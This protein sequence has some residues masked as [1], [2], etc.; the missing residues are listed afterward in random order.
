MET[1]EVGRKYGVYDMVGVCF[2]FVIVLLGLSVVGH[3]NG[4]SFGCG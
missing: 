4:W 3:G 2:H 1:L